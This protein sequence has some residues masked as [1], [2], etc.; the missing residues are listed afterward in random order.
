MRRISLL[1]VALGVAAVVTGLAGA[2]SRDTKIALV[3]Y[4]TPKEA[5]SH[6]IPAFQATPA[7]KDVSFT[8]SYGASGDQARA[9]VAGLPADVVDLS[10]AP[11]V[12]TLVKAGLDRQELEQGALQRHGQRLRGRV[13]AAER[14]PEAHQD[15]GRPDQAGRPG[16]DP[17]PVH[18]G[19]RALERDGRVR[20]PAPRGQDPGRRR[21]RTSA[22]SSTTSSSQDTSARDR[23]ADVPRRQGRRPARPTRTRR[24][25]PQRAN[26]PVYYLIPKATLL[27]REPRRGHEDGAARRRRPSSRYLARR[28]R[29]RCSASRATAR[30][31]R[32]CA[33][34]SSYPPRPQLF[35]INYVGG[36][37]KVTK[38]FFDPKN[39]VMAKIEQRSGGVDWRLTPPRVSAA[40][41]L[42][43]GSAVPVGVGIA[44]AYL[45][46]IVLLPLAAL[47]WQVGAG[48]LGC[49]LGRDLEPGGGRGAEADARRL[50]RRRADQRGRRDARSPGCSCATASAG[51]SLVNSVIDLPFALPT[52]VA[53]LTLLALYGPHSP[54]RDR[55]RL[56]AHG[57]PD[58]AALRDAARSSCA[59]CSRCCSSS[60]ARWRRRPPRSA[61]AASRSSGGSSS[62]TCCPAILS[63][64]ALAFARAIGEFGSVVL[65]SGNLPFKT[66]VASV[67]IFGRIESNDSA[68]PRPSRSC[69]S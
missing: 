1:V 10:L 36:W 67:F 41:R 49:V 24:S 42:R 28:R 48:R 3:A 69:C 60:T 53:G 55:R 31:T 20:R 38:Q 17:E 5:F 32:R 4:S 18:L 51:K 15:L 63:G 34:S 25:S 39:G 44:T 52:I 40:P 19:R 66:E 54:G 12:D 65:I 35:T 59:P 50:A 56:H 33:S 58:G 22:S 46:L 64:V 57:D 9:V 14:K 45:S 47:V 13:R 23:A 68:R 26:Q 61:P 21:P 43:A 27:D 16:R 29:R 11:D 62:R 7:G 30:S 8:Q 37:D 6:L 2:A